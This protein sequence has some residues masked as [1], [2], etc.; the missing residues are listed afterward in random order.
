MT[1]ITGKSQLMHWPP[2]I[3]PTG[4][5]PDAPPAKTKSQPSMLPQTKL[6]A[7]WD[8]FEDFLGWPIDLLMR[9]F[10]KRLFELAMTV[11]MMGEGLLLMLSPRSIEASSFRYLIDVVPIWLC[12][13]LFA[14]LG[15]ARIIALALNGHWMPHGAYVR[16]VGAVAG[17]FM[18]A[19]MGAS[20]LVNNMAKGDPVSP[21]I[22]IYA[23]LTLFE[24]VSVYFALVG[25]R[26]YGSSQ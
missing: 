25:A 3:R 4:R 16:A 19:Q 8:R 23:T 22:P 26:R 17:A 5:M 11:A 9:H 6:G 10:E 2:S 1:Q 24:V 20:L 21:G 7:A 15:G 18:W 13:I 14:W 12:I